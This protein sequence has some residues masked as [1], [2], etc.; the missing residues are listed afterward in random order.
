MARNNLT[1]IKDD[2]ARS[3]TFITT[4]FIR[5]RRMSN[6]HI[7]LVN[8]YLTIKDADGYAAVKE[9]RVCVYGP[10]AELAYRNVHKGS[11]LGVIGEQ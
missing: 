7:Y 1:W 3:A 10:R 2:I 9:L 8:L 6:I 11:R 4:T 5:F